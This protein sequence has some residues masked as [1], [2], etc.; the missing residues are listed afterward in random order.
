MYM[1]FI[2]EQKQEAQTLKQ[3]TANE[4]FLETLLLFIKCDVIW[5]NTK[6]Y[7]VTC[8]QSRNSSLREYIA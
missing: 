3:S 4:R 6:V 8:E 7:S 2:S 5:M 1:Y